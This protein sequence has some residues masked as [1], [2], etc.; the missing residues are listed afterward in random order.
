[1]LDP[2]LSQPHLP[3][4]F[5]LPY[6]PGVGTST[7]AELALHGTFVDETVAEGDGT[8]EGFLSNHASS[9]HEKEEQ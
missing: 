9:A 1:M 7:D 5:T 8:E 3:Y 2:I 6:L 4:P